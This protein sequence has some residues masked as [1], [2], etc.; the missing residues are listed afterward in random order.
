MSK[1]K[2]SSSNSTFQVYPDSATTCAACPANKSATTK[3]FQATSITSW[4]QTELSPPTT[5]IS[6]VP[7][8][9]RTRWF[10]AA[11]I[12]TT[13]LRLLRLGLRTMLRGMLSRP[14]IS[15]FRCLSLFCF[16]LVARFEFDVGG[17]CLY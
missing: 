6:P 1:P 12:G 10:R 3:T 14:F 16:V 11:I 15:S 7:M 9:G 2:P 13:L 8:L 4:T 17:T 5:S